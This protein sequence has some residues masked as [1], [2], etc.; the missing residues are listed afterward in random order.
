M[1]VIEKLLKPKKQDVLKSVS[2]KQ[3]VLVGFIICS[4]VDPC[5]LIA[6][7]ERIVLPIRRAQSFVIHSFKLRHYCLN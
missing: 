3:P 2:E 6:A 4:T 1:N 7:F 5:Q